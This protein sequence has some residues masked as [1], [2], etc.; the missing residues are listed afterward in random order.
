MDV[1][2]IGQLQSGMIP[3]EPKPAQANPAGAAFADVV[4]DFMN[5]INDYQVR[6][7]AE[8]EKVV[9]GESR[10]L[11]DVMI[12]MNKA[13]LTFRVFMEVRDQAINAYQEIMRMQL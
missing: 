7:D 6:A 11:H 2:A 3:A 13:D 1:A 8:V 4:Q 5:S 12:A 9:T 10:N